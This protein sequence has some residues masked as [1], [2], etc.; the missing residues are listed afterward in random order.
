[1]AKRVNEGEF[2]KDRY[3]DDKEQS[4]L[5]AELS[6]EAFWEERFRERGRR[7]MFVA[8]ADVL[9]FRSLVQSNSLSELHAIYSDVV[10]SVAR[11]GYHNPGSTNWSRL[12]MRVVS[13]S[14]ILWSDAERGA[15]F[16][17]IYSAVRFLLNAGVT[18]GLPLRAAL[19]WGEAEHFAEALPGDPPSFAVEAVLGSAFVRAFEIEHEQ[20]WTGGVVLQAAL[21]EGR[22]GTEWPGDDFGT[23]YDV[24]M[25]SGKGTMMTAI[26]W[27]QARFKRFTEA[28]I[29]AAFAAHGKDGSSDDVQEKIANTLEFVRRVGWLE[30]QLDL[31]LK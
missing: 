23:A 6:R 15:G 14:I 10:K 31:T 18:S 26:N 21:D 1:M 28:E 16:R 11:A 17:Q 24:P 9:G 22:D 30:E 19:T 27:P 4:Q 13:D 3:Y 7:T 2:D 8:F 5:D 25:K 29:R 20:Q 12:S